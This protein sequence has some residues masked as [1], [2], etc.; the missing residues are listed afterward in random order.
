MNESDGPSQATLRKRR[1]V[2]LASITRL[3]TKLREL[4]TRAHEPSALKLAHRMSQKIES[5]DSEFR[6]HHFALIDVVPDEDEETLLKEQKTLDKHDDDVAELAV[7]VERLT[8]T[9]DSASDSGTRKVVSR[10][11]AHLNNNIS[12]VDAAISSLEGSAELHLVHQYQEQL[13]DLKGE[14]ADVRRTLLSLG[15]E[16]GD[17][18]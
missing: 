16:E 14:L 13:T 1:G 11:I 8:A 15:L 10:M 3:A 4:E 18:L 17:A 2:V 12:A 5:L 6:A 9:C 7:R